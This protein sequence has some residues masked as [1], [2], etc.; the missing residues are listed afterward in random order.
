[1]AHGEKLYIQRCKILKHHDAPCQVAHATW[2]S[3]IDDQLCHPDLESIP[4]IWNHVIIPIHCKGTCWDTLTGSHLL[5]VLHETWSKNSMM[6]NAR[7]IHEK[8]SSVREFDKHFLPRH[9][10]ACTIHIIR[11][12]G[13]NYKTQQLKWQLNGQHEN[14][15]WR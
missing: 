13:S 6:I 3:S 10:T 4:V 15:L 7:P 9:P 8:P 14:V 12:R 5:L 2:V 1:M 11:N